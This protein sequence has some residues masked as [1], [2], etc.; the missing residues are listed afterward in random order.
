MA[1]VLLP[2]SL[3]IFLFLSSNVTNLSIV[4]LASGQKEED[5]NLSFI[6]DLNQ[7]SYSKLVE[8]EYDVNEIATALREVGNAMMS[9]SSLC[10]IIDSR[11]S[12]N[13]LA[14]S[15]SGYLSDFNFEEGVSKLYGARDLLA[16][17]QMNP[18]FEALDGFAKANSEAA[19]SMYELLVKATTPLDGMDNLFLPT[20]GSRNET[21]GSTSSLS[22]ILIEAGRSTQNDAWVTMGERLMTAISNFEQK[23]N[24]VNSITDIANSADVASLPRNEF[25]LYAI[26]FTVAGVLIGGGFIIRLLLKRK[27]Q[28]KYRI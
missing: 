2:L 28:G 15:L 25:Q 10:S 17:F 4:E 23:Y 6:E 26:G 14:L 1:I 20:D 7:S 22:T 19:K 11:D 13:T 18:S 12:C 5:I 24:D 9:N 3:L 16:E 21:Q 27:K 8:D